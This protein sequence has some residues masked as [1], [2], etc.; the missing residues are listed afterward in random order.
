MRF[1]NSWQSA[2]EDYWILIFCY[3][4]P[5]FYDSRKGTDFVQL[6]TK[7]HQTLPASNQKL[8]RWRDCHQASLGTYP[9]QNLDFGVLVLKALK[10]QISDDLHQLLW[11]MFGEP[12]NSRRCLLRSFLQQLKNNLNHSLL[13]DHPFYLL[14]DLRAFW[15]GLSLMYFWCDV[16]HLFFS[17]FVSFLWLLLKSYWFFNTSFKFHRSEEGFVLAC[18]LLH[19]CLSLVLFPRC[20]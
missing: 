14:K 11:E 17:P 7:K 1:V 8:G 6:Q 12:G 10:L 5:V 9:F 18:P 13:L 16:V 3:Y 19:H 15:L 2:I 4:C 20:L